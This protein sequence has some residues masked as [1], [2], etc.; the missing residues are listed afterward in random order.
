MSIQSEINR[1]E[2]NVANT[3]AVLEALGADMP[4]EQNSDNLPTTAGSA[5]VVLYSE[6]TLT[7]AQ[8]AQARENIGAA[9]EGE[10]GSGGASV[11]PDWN[12]TDDTAADF[13]KNKPF[14]DGLVEVMPETEV[15]GLDEDGMFV[16]SLD[17]SLFTGDE[18]RLTITFDGTEYVCEA[19]DLYGNTAFGNAGIMGEADSGEP[20]LLIV[21]LEYGMAIC[22]FAD[23]DAHTIGIFKFGTKPIDSK[24]L[25]NNQ[26]Y[27]DM[28]YIYRNSN[29][30]DA[31]NRI[32]KDEL[33]AYVRRENIV[34]I[35]VHTEISEESVDLWMFA[36]AVMV[37]SVYE[38]GG[39][40]VLNEGE[41]ISLYTAEYTPK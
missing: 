25:P 35:G 40:V 8:K 4:S 33:N 1:I 2:Q 18:T 22:A 26:L 17:V 27:T 10:G 11:Q 7:D 30:S 41:L 15:I 9:A 29:T 34:R 16:Y 12:Q 14:G 32:T 13:I 38:Y 31:N 36:S 28:T 5:K 39:V 21:S 20:F 3:Y 23:A 24:Y 19:Y 6:Q 37:L